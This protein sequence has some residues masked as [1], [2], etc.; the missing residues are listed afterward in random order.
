MGED[1][2]P[3]CLANIL[4]AS[5]IYKGNLQ[6]ISNDLI[7]GLIAATDTSRNA[8]ITTMVHLIKME[9]SRQKVRDE[10]NG[11]LKEKGISD[12]MQISNTEF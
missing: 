5:E 12:I 7:I 11:Y 4:L 6:K 8:T 1:D 2:Q 3:K 9:A 10:V